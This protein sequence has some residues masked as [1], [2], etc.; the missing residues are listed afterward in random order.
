MHRGNAFLAAGQLDKALTDY[1]IVLRHNPKDAWSL[2]GR[3]YVR[4]KH[5]DAPAGNADMAAAK[6]I[7][8]GIAAAF[9]TRGI[10]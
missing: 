5:G 6:A 7:E 1:E 10:K 2:Y 3:G 9:E 8:A 4:L